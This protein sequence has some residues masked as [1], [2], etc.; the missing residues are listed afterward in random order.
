[1]KIR[2]G[3]VSNSSSAAFIIAYD[4]NFFG[5]LI[6]LLKNSYLGCETYFNDVNVLLEELSE[7]DKQYCQNIIDQKIKEGKTVE[8]IILDREFNVIFDLLKQISEQN[9]NDKIEFIFKD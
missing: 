2:N 7:K 1:M 6:S 4:K 5:D 3:Y 8:Y 9:G